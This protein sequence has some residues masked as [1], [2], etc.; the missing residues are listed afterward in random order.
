MIRLRPG[1][2]ALT[3]RALSHVPLGKQSSVLDIGCG[4]GESIKL[5]VDN[6]GARVAG[7]EPD[8]MRRQ[9]ARDLNP[10]VEILAATGEEMPFADQSFDLVLAECSASLFS[11][12]DL[13]FAQIYRVL[14]PQGRL[15][16]TDVYARGEE[17]IR[18]DG[19]LRNLYSEQ[20]FRDFLS[21]AGFSVRLVEDCGGILKSMLLELIFEYGRDKAYQ[22]IGL[23]CC[24]AK[25]ARLGYIFILAE[26]K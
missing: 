3:E 23:D 10:G 1:G 16:L 8:E 14:K 18:A 17:D 5:L 21:A 12:I 15:I 24:L 2:M 20:Q 25:Q 13:A 7:L 9:K 4:Y 19:L 6:Y 11:N 26:K 22:M